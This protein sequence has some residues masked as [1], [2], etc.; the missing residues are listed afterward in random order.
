MLVGTL[1]EKS[2]RG[3][4]QSKTLRARRKRRGFRQVVER[5][6]PLVLW[7]LQPGGAPGKRYAQ[8]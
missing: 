4:P 7:N 1:V 6:G 8:I 3:L 2:G 5:A